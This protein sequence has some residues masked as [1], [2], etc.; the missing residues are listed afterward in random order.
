MLSIFLFNVFNVEFEKVEID[1]SVRVIVIIGGD[2]VFVVGVDIKE[3]KDKECM[4]LVFIIY[5]FLFMFY[6]SC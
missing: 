4:F 5:C 2:K 3:M 6:F 1:D